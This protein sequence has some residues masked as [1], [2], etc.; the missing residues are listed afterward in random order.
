MKLR[1]TN[2]AGLFVTLETTPV[3]FDENLP[4]AGQVKDGLDFTSDLLWF[5]DTS[6][7]EGM[8]LSVRFFNYWYLFFKSISQILKVDYFLKK[9]HALKVHVHEGMAQV[10]FYMRIFS[11]A[12]V[13]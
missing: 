4:V 7:I 3:L 12:F 9:T 2:C 10:L 5:N 6:K 13:T 8:N 1:V 11:K